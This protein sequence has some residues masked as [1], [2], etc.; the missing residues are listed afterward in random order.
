[1]T[2]S[3]ET[4]LRYV[5]KLAEVNAKASQL[6]IQYVQKHGFSDTEGLIAT[7]FNL[8]D[9]YGEAAAAAACDLYDAI[10]AAEGVIVPP[11][12]PAQPATYGE[13]AKAVQG[14]MK[15]T[16]NQVP[17]TVG[18]LV[19]QT[20]ADT[21]LQNAQRDGAQFAWVPHGDTCAFCMTLASRGWQYMSK[22]ALKNG[23]AEH[24][25]A[26]CNCEYCVR[27]D[28]KSE[29]E[30]YDPDEYKRIYDEAEGSSPQE[31]I[32]S[33]RR[34]IAAKRR[35]T[36]SPELTNDNADDILKTAFEAAEQSRFKPGPDERAIVSEVV[37]TPEYE[38]RIRNLGENED[39]SSIITHQARTTLWRRNGTAYED[40]IF[41]DPQTG[42]WMAQRN[43]DIVGGVSPT[44]KMKTMA[45]ER[46]HRIIAIHNHPHNMLPSYS[47]LVNAKHYSYGVILGHNGI[48]MKY[49]V[50]DVADIETA[51]KIL[52]Y[53]QKSLSEGKD[54]TPYYDMLDALGVHL[55]VIV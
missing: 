23:H 19:K 2:I 25:H 21:M 13:V 38:D 44:E 26:N 51:D 41:I 18:R 29:V 52:D 46:P 16:P 4:W 24:I 49:I 53:M 55:K 39:I 54:M 45:S 6:M 7:A 47:D 28:G 22:K 34:G 8:A 48:I 30:G 5:N 50:S 14:T 32:N 37:A 36:K 17:Q 35:A 40:L 31:K 42:E 11:A 27:F 1:M 33:I 12:V 20:G 15:K 10:A 43:L 9:Y 3:K